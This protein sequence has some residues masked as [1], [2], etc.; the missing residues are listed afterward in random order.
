[1]S[2]QSTTPVSPA[3]SHTP[4][5]PSPSRRR[6]ALDWLRMLPDRPMRMPSA[7]VV[8]RIASNRARFE[9]LVA[10]ML[11]ASL[12]DELPPVRGYRGAYLV[13][14]LGE[15]RSSQHIDLLIRALNTGWSWGWDEL[16][17]AFTRIGGPAIDPLCAT[18]LNAD[19]PLSTRR[20][21]VRS[22]ASVAIAACDYGDE[23][24][25]IG[26]ADAQYR[27]AC[28]ALMTLLDRAN[29]ED[30][31][32]LD[33]SAERL[34][35]LRWG[36]AL[37]RI[38]DLFARGLLRDRDGF[39][40]GIARQLIDGRLMQFDLGAWRMSLSDWLMTIGTAD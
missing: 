11:E 5:I 18:V 23:S 24:D 33:E 26:D 21:A 36:S 1:M 16:V 7:R 4:A 40:L 2:S 20:R 28:G 27:T 15:W 25:W 29:T 35:E 8:G 34:C 31:E 37:A 22:L 12:T 3:P 6:D 13:T 10:S 17:H 39:N 30:T 19:L 38:E 32:L 9:P 14:F